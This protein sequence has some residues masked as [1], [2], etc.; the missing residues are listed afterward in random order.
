MGTKRSKRFYPVIHCASIDRG[1][2]LHAEN[3]TQTALNNGADGIF[4]IG[5]G[6]QA[7]DLREIYDHLRNKFPAAWIG[8][9]FLGLSPG[10]D[11]YGLYAHT[12][13]CK[14]LNALWLDDLPKSRILDLPRSI[15]VFGGVAFKYKNPY[16]SERGL[17]EACRT[18]R[19]SVDVPTTSGDR[20]GSPPPVSKLQAIRQLVGDGVLLAVAS[21]VSAKNVSPLLPYADVFLVASSITRREEMHGY[22]L[23][24]PDR[25]RTLADIIHSYKAQ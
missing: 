10:R 17:E 6:M 2:C 25:V 13:M 12:M 5:H 11:G 23:F 21:G 9:N 15:Q 1:G 19:E 4:L 22:E 16:L 3:C 7:R 8:I 18:A 20:T 14:D 24:V